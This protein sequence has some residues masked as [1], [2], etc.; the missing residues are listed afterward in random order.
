MTRVELRRKQ[1]GALLAVGAGRA[2]IVLEAHP[3]ART[4]ARRA[5]IALL[6]LAARERLSLELTSPRRA[7]RA[8]IR[9][10]ATTRVLAGMPGDYGAVRKLARVREPQVLQ[11]VGRDRYGR[12]QFLAPAA[13][14]AWLRMQAAA[15]HDGVVLELVSA[16]R[17]AAYQAALVARK[18]AAGRTLEQVL[19][20][21]AA[22]GYSEH[23]GGDTIDIATPGSRPLEEEFET[24]E[25]FRWLA[26]RGGEF[27]FRL[28]FPRDNVH[29]I[30][31]EPWHW[32]YVRG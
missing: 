23:H 6:P 1:D 21:N 29:G 30:S 10:I 4:E 17:S 18:V 3:A 12:E 16:F 20:V 9:A 11:S 24:T 19:E 2:R 7:L 5:L 31:F 32:R 26:S 28:S 8:P 27:S 25:A 14:R 22:P 15:R 13:A